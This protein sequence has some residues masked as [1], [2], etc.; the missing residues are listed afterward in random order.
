MELL[1]NVEYFRNIEQ[2]LYEK[3]EDI[4]YLSVTLSTKNGCVK[5]IGI[6]IC[7]AENPFFA[8]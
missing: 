1:Q 6:W 5:E 4:N 8:P 7:K 3:V 2:L